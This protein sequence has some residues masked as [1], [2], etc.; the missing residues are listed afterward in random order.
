M[1]LF[2]KLII[3]YIGIII[4]DLKTKLFDLYNLH[5]VKGNEFNL[6]NNIYIILYDRHGNVYRDGWLY[7]IKCIDNIKFNNF[8]RD[9]LTELYENFDFEFGNLEPICFVNNSIV[10]SLNI[11]N[12]ISKNNYNKI[13]KADLNQIEQEVF[14]IFYEQYLNVLKNS[15]QNKEIITNK[16]YKFRY[17]IHNYIVKKFLF[18]K[19]ESI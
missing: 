18:T 9:I 11:L 19:K 10:F 17:L 8:T 14:N 4:R 5:E 1:V 6:K 12:D 3:K 2:R 7:E 13:K 16:K 15:F